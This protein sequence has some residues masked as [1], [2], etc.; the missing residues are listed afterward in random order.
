ML[1][2]E[3][4]RE[5]AHL[6]RLD[7]A[8]AGLQSLHHDLDKILDFVEKI[9]EIDTSSVTGTQV[10]L[11]TRNI[12]REDKAGPVIEPSEIAKRAPEWEFGHFVVPGIIET[13]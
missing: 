4:F 9:K 7:P 2:D 6:A 11:D 8:D 10:F 13:E 5:L 1:S 3:E 12:A